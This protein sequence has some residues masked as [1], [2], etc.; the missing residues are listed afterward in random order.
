LAQTD[1]AIAPFAL[2]VAPK[3]TGGETT[4]SPPPTSR[5]GE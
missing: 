5:F 4:L 2:L 3:T 1:G